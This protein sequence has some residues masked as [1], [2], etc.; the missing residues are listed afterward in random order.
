[1]LSPSVVVPAAAEQQ[2]QAALDRVRA[3]LEIPVDFPAAALAEAE[4]AAAAGPGAAEDRTDLE[5]VTIDPPGSRDLDQAVAIERRPGGYVLSYAI[6]D[7]AAF[8]TPGGALDAAVQ[9]R[10]VTVYGP[11]GSIPLHPPALSAGA[12]SLLPGEIRPACVWRLVLDDDG[13]L[14][15]AD[16]RRGLVRSRAQLT[17]AQV[18]A[19]VDGGHDPE[20]PAHLPDLLREVGTARQAQEHARGGVSL[21]LPE[22]EVVPADGGYALELRATLPV[23]GWNAQISLLTGIAAAGIMRECGIGVLRTLEEADPRDL[24][25]LRRTARALG[26]DWPAAASYP[27]LVRGLDSGVPAHAAFLT[28]A[29]SLFR[30]AGYLAFGVD[31]GAGNGRPDAGNG[32]PGSGDGPAPAGSRHAAIAAEYAHV[33]APLRR[34]VDRYGLEV[35]LAARAGQEVPDWV[36]TALPS[37]PR[38]MARTTQR[39]SRFE[40]AAVNVVEALVL[41]GREGETFEGVVVD[42]DE[43][44]RG[45]V[46]VGE[47]AVRG[48]VTGADLPLGEPVRVRLEAVDAVEHRVRFVLAGS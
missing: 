48:E 40:N 36:R 24:A 30:G 14:R 44:G 32:R 2:V 12:A 8:V 9:E 29:T 45:T 43:A 34:L 15:E 21:D 1:M 41:A 37:L 35:C 31:P 26:I 19:V 6:A 39:A 23:E 17:Y 27:D 13:T 25:R 7:V 10:G 38:T 4:R 5:L 3:E 11:T 47:P 28:A 33:T 20:V 16:V 46:V 42:L 22:Q 18:Q